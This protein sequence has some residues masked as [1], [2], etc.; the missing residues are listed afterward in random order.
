MEQRIRLDIKSAPEIQQRWEGLFKEFIIGQERAIRHLVRR[1]LYANSLGGALRDPNKPA[2]T[3]MYLGPTGVG[4]TR[5]IEVFAELLFGSPHAMVKIDCSELRERHE[6]AR[7]IGA[8][9]GYIRSD[10]EPWLSQRRLDHWGFMSQTNNAEVNSRLHSLHEQLIEIQTEIKQLKE[11]YQI[12]PEEKDSRKF[13]KEIREKIKTHAGLF[14]VYNVLR[15]SM[16]YKPG[17]YPAILLFD[18]MEKAH[19]ALFELLLQVHD[20]ACLTL[21][22]SNLDEEGKKTDSNEVF[23]H[24]TFIFYTSNINQNMMKKMISNTGM[25]F[26]PNVISGQRL[27]RQVYKTTLGQLEK[28]FQPEFLGRIGKENIS[29]FSPLSKEQI[30]E[31][32]DRI[33]LPEFIKR[34]VYCFPI[35]LNITE[36][37]RN[38]LV[39]ESYDVK[40]KIF[41]MRAL[42]GVFARRVEDP[43]VGLTVRSSEE[44]GIAPGDAITIDFKDGELAFYLYNDQ[45]I[46]P[47]SLALT[48]KMIKA[49]RVMNDGKMMSTFD[50]KKP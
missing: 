1:V 38:F 23:F 15:M 50:F 8:P 18:E 10:E 47:E 20:K 41:G 45:R 7:L 49:V 33:I 32:L 9:P 28:L 4:K 6:L 31:G 35:E 12:P 43:I 24:N 16:K 48:E 13:P 30:R 29:V 14:G 42:K 39:D 21:H 44:G 46:G 3:F 37:A 27:D 2:G 25:G 5:L 22:G 34:F 17:S 40:N 36:S 19:P 26:A 11:N